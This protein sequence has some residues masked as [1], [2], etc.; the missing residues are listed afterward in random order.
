MF[1]LLEQPV[2]MRDNPDEL[3]ATQFCAVAI[4]IHNIVLS[5][6]SSAPIA[7]PTLS[8]IFCIPLS[9]PTCPLLPRVTLSL[10]N[11]GNTSLIRETH[12]TDLTLAISQ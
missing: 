1:T 9:N 7:Y 2:C 12:M 11:Q 4:S 5:F 10:S 8:L 3:V 6:L